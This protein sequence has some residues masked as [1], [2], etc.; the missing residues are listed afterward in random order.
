MSNYILLSF[1]SQVNLF[2]KYVWLENK[3]QIQIKKIILAV[4]FLIMSLNKI[5]EF[6]KTLEI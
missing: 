3:K 5:Y 4:Y 1:A 6:I 2:F